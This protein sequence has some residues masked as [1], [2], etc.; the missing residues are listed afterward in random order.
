MERRLENPRVAELARL[1]RQ[2]NFSLERFEQELT[3]ASRK[4]DRSE[5]L[6]QLLEDWTGL[7]L[8]PLEAADA[9]KELTALLPAFREKMGLPLGLPTLLLHYFHGRLG[10]MKD[11]RLIEGKEL[12]ALRVSAITDPLTALYNRR[13]LL[14]QLQREIAR[15]ERTGAVVAAVMID[16]KGF[17]AVNDRFGHA[18]GDRVLARAARVIRASLRAVDAGCRWGGDEFVLVLPHTDFLSAF[19]VAERIRRRV[20]LRV[21]PAPEVAGVDMHYGIASYPTDGKTVD[22]LL[23]VADVRLYQCREQ[24]NFEGPERRHSPRFTPD[25]MTVR[26]HGEGK[27]WTAP[28]VDVSYG[29]IAIEAPKPGRWPA[30]WS[31]EIV[32]R[33]DPQTHPVRLRA[34]HSTSSTGGNV[35]VGCSYA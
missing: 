28:I 23:R 15:A 35:R 33:H 18:A 19:A 13:F 27:A 12:E 25:D 4:S 9:W 1:G 24:L 30:R 10:R 14:E 17:K 29:G 16:L 34:R 22:F 11:P 3:S 20:S 2:K 26:V 7:A 5:I 21:R 8:S 32:R 6:R 31:A